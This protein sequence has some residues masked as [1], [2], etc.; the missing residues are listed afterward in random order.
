VM[1]MLYLKEYTFERLS[2]VS[3]VG[4]CV[5]RSTYL[6]GFRHLDRDLPALQ[7]QCRGLS[8]QAEVAYRLQR[9]CLGLEGGSGAAST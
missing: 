2:G 5:C 3:A 7:R 1:E 9:R 8:Y 6:L 4:S